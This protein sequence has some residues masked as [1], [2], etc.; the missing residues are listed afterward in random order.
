MKNQEQ[1]YLLKG[2]YPSSVTVEKGLNT[3]TYTYKLQVFTE[4]GTP[5]T[6]T[7]TDFEGGVNP[8]DP[9]ILEVPEYTAPIGTAGTP[10]V[11]EKPEF[12]GGTVP[13]DAPV[14]DVPAI[15]VVNTPKQPNSEQKAEKPS[16]TELLPNTG[17]AENNI[18]QTIGLGLLSSFG[19]VALTSRKKQD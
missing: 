7:N 14:L 16:T 15:E 5:E 2:D 9:P 3:I 8:L 18:L 4:K 13:M 12:N 6:T 10:E 17:V 19:L 11:H 1:S